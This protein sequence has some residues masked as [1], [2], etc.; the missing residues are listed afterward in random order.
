[1]IQIGHLWK[2]YKQGAKSRRIDQV[3]FL[4]DVLVSTMKTKDSSDN[5]SAPR[6][7]LLRVTLTFATSKQ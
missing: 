6:S 7:P 4:G 5:A 1:M 3:S 2:D